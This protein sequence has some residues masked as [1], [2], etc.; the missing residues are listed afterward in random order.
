[1]VNVSRKAMERNKKMKPIIEL[2]KKFEKNYGV[3][4][5]KVLQFAHKALPMW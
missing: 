5:W 3:Y 1:M 4:L 2:R